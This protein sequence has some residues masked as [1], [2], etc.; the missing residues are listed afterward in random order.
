MCELDWCDRRGRNRSGSGLCEAHY[1]QKRRGRPFTEARRYLPTSTP[2]V[3]DGCE[4]TG[5]TGRYCPKHEVRIR[6]HG[7]P[8]TVIAPEDRA[9]RR[10][11]ES[12]YWA[13]E[14][15]GYSGAH[16]RLRKER[17]PAS[18][19]PCADC[20]SPAAQWSYN[21][22]DPNEKANEYRGVAV[23][24]STDPSQY[25]PRCVPCHKRFDL[26]ALQEARQW[27]A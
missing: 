8:H 16:Q 2:C 24:Y 6:R 5:F 20:G 15:V 1:Y 7:D 10:G 22:A 13:G 26:S 11:E 25:E 3:V 19:H 21:R 4:N 23:V 27:N 14:G 9:Y 18:A 17:G 12:E